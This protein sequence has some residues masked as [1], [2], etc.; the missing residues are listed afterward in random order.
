[1]SEKIYLTHA[2]VLA[3]AQRIAHGF[4][5]PPA[6]FPKGLIK[7]HPVPRGGVPVAYLLIGLRDDITIVNDPAQA[8]Y[9]VDDLIDSGGTSKK[10]RAAYPRAGFLALYDKRDERDTEAQGWLVFPWEK[11]DASSDD[12]IIGTITNR[13]REEGVDFKANSNI[14]DHLLVGEMEHVE[15]EVEKRAGRLLD[16]LLID[17]ENCHN[18]KDTPKRLAKMFCREIFAGRFRDAPDLTFFPNAAKL[19]EMM[20]TGPISIR[21]T[22]SHHF[23]PIIG[24]A[25]VG[26]IPGAKLVGL[27][28]FNRII[29]WLCSRP[30]IQEEL[31]VQV[32]D[33]LEK[34]LAPLGLAVVIDAS[35]ACMT[36][37]GVKEG[38]EAAMVTSVMRGRLKES[39][40]T[41][42]EFLALIK[43]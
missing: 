32:A 11:D 13:F 1:M 9:F 33:F 25:W 15:R 29:E 12:S 34:E 21:S 20:V 22:C 16:A 24:R 2:Q 8:D 37:R 39:A 26:I 23:C 42:A 17:R 40:P 5:Y 18:S 36:W 30:Q 3:R 27:S 28:K 35:H 38:P 31:A 10:W 19:D 41:R 6:G 7:I 4:G 14:A 43:R